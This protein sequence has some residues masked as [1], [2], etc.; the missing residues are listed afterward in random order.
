ML[1]TL[2]LREVSTG[3]IRSDASNFRLVQLGHE[4]TYPTRS[5]TYFEKLIIIQKNS[6]NYKFENYMAWK[7]LLE[8]PICLTSLLS[9]L[10]TPL[11]TVRLGEVILLKNAYHN[12]KTE[13]AKNF[14]SAF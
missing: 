11:S 7:D 3:K 12:T 5:K 4:S 10:S 1:K 14:F 8:P 9:F 13:D 6:T 2:L